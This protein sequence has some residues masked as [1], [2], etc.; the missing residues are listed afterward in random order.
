MLTSLYVEGSGPLH[1]I[2]AGRKLAGLAI[3]GAG[4]FL[5][6]A[7]LLLGLALL[8]AVGLYLTAGLPVGQA[9]RRLVPTLV[10]VALLMVFNLVFLS[11][12]EVGI[13]TLRIL[14]LVF[15]AAA[16]TATTPLPDMMEAIS[17]FLRPLERIGLLRAGDAGLVVGLCLRFVPEIVTRYRALTEAH[18]ARGLKVRP[19]TLLGPL[20]ILTLR[21]ADDIAA[22]IDAR[23]LRA[24][25]ASPSVPDKG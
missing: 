17:R 15:A 22:A 4:L 18:R 25:K 21:Q 6:R 12:S 3:A 23:G 7:P 1:R 16:V 14:A 24:A 11:P 2:S 8:I 9:L 10:S 5:V 19:L 20:I 13:L